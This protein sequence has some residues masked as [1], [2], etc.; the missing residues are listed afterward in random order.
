[1]LQYDGNLNT[2]QISEKLLMVRDRACSHHPS[3]E[4]GDPGFDIRRAP[5]IKFSR[6]RGRSWWRNLFKRAA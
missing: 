2:V 5:D 3:I 6:A 4:V 1:M